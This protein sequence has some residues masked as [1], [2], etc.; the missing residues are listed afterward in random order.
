[1]KKVYLLRRLLLLAHLSIELWGRTHRGT[2]NVSHPV[3]NHRCCQHHNRRTDNCLFVCSLNHGKSNWVFENTY[4]VSVQN[5]YSNL[6]NIFSSVSCPAQYRIGIR[7][8]FRI[9]FRSD[10]G[11]RHTLTYLVCVQTSLFKSL[12]YI[13]LCQLSSPITIYCRP[14]LAPLT[15]T[16]FGNHIDLEKNV[17]TH[18]RYVFPKTKLSMFWH[19]HS[20]VSLDWYF[21]TFQSFKVFYAFSFSVQNTFL[22]LLCNPVAII[23]YFIS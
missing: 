8:K 10:F 3:I 23:H 12:Q 15:L 2:I 22:L 11:F 13:F 6:Y 5:F 1:M 4:L 18:T 19:Q 14:L 7:K 21:T 20:I 9:R 16:L 17:C